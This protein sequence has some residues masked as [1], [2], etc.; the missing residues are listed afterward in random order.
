MFVVGLFVV[1]VVATEEN[2]L[3]FYQPVFF[4]L[5]VGCLLLFIWH[6]VDVLREADPLGEGGSDKLAS[7]VPLSRNRIVGFGRG[8]LKA[9]IIGA[10]FLVLVTLPQAGAAL[11]RLLAYLF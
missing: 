1:G 7:F 10:S 2:F 11:W 4:F 6:D 9:R 3:I 5:V 8:L